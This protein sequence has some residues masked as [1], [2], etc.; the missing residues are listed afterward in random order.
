MP[1]IHGGVLWLAWDR[2]AAFQPVFIPRCTAQHCQL[3]LRPS[4]RL[5]RRMLIRPATSLHTPTSSPAHYTHTLAFCPSTSPSLNPLAPGLIHLLRMVTGRMTTLIRYGHFNLLVL[6]LGLSPC[7]C[8]IY[9][10]HLPDQTWS[11]AEVE[12]LT[13]A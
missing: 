12:W 2:R 11:A 4:T 8:A 6:A 5:N 3:T 7:S 1:D 13:K 10:D 9:S